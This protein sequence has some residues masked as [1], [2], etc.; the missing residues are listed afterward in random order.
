MSIIQKNINCDQVNINSPLERVKGKY[1]S[2]ISY[3]NVYTPMYI[4]TPHIQYINSSDSEVLISSNQLAST[5]EELEE[6]CKQVIHE[7]SESFFNGKH[8]SRSKI[9]T[10]FISCVQSGRIMCKL[11]PNLKI[12]DQRNVERN[13]T[14]FQ[15][16]MQ[17][18]AILYVKGIMYKK[19]TI[20]LVI[21]VEQL[22]IYLRDMLDTWCI[23]TEYTPDV[24][25]EETTQEQDTEDEDTQDTSTEDETEYEKISTSDPPQETQDETQ[26]E[27]PQ[28][29]PQETLQ[30]TPQ[31]TQDETQDETPQETQDETPQETQQDETIVV[32][33]ENPR[34]SEKKKRTYKR[35]SKSV[36]SDNEGDFF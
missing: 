15:E 11:S 3:G 22:K 33:I 21:S 27:T 18:V 17:C 12:R 16:D 13:P 19:N 26:D 24:E 10:S 14:D 8:F 20:Q 2:F 36:K 1:F 31:E 23:Q 9:D 29:T 35:K 34:I 4:Q 32:N 30:E 25:L 28:E 5:L 7:N 6:K